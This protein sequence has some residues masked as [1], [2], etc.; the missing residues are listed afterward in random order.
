MTMGPWGVH[1][2]RTQTW[3]DFVP[4]WHDYLARCQ[5]MLRQGLFAADICY[6]QPEAAP[7]GFQEHNR[8]SHDYDNCSAEVVLTRM[9]VRDGRLVL[10]DG[11]SYHLLVLPDVPTMTPAL[12]RKISELVQAGATVIGPRPRKS[13]SLADYPVCDDEVKKLA[14]QVWADCDGNAVKERTF[15]RGRVV[16]GVPPEEFLRKAGVQP[17]FTSWARLD[18]IHRLAPDRDIYF[19]A[20]PRPQPVTAACI[21]RVSGRQP[22]LWWPDTGRI[23]PAAV[24]A[25]KDGGT[26]V[27]LPLPP[28]GSVFVVF[29]KSDRPLDPI[30]AVTCDGKTILS[31]TQTAPN[32]VVTKALYGVLSDPQRTRDVVRKV[33]QKVDA[34]EYSFQVARLAEGDD[35]AFNVVK[36]LV[37]EYR[38][39]DK[40]FT[41]TGND[42]D[43]VHLTGDSARIVVE[44]AVYG[45]LGDPQR[46][47]DVR[48]KLQHIL[49]TGESSFQVARLAQGDDPAVNVVK[50]L[51]LEYTL[52]GRRL[53][54]TGTDPQNIVLYEPPA[55]EHIVGIHCDRQG[56]PVLEA[57]RPGQYVLKTASGRTLQMDVPSLP[58]LEVTGPWEVRFPPKWGAP[59]RITL[60]KLAS[61]TDH[62][63]PGV[64]YFSG[65][66]TYTKTITVPNELLTVNRRLILDLGTVRV[67]ARLKLNGKDL[68]LLWSQPFR[69]DVTQTVRPG[70]NTL[71]VSVVNLWV[72]RLIGD[73]Q[74][75]EDSSRNPDG[76]LK[77]WPQ[78]LA[79]DSPSPTGR[80][81]F[82]TWRLWKKD[83]PLQPSG[84]IG[85]VTLQA[86][87][88]IA[89]TE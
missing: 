81:T 39:G 16:C 42:T 31:A 48:E 13:P 70:E 36:T 44:K 45:V 12:L 59:E 25:E 72:N 88:I 61:W 26:S 14:D 29:R 78:W 86:T 28:G 62:T 8:T 46:T 50:T 34:G 27:V 32:V 22:E 58:Q 47:R 85:P 53:S 80:F 17:D 55:D 63:D 37:V 75:P 40:S 77:E 82:T 65:T 4:A 10:P 15:G 24:F 43:T 33:Q 51:I 49:D 1:Y 35:P 76:T 67:M 57:R 21:F 52:E 54:A 84:L 73:E 87:Q 60:E 7:Q 74:L 18:Y 19:V 3:W 71:E 9:T 11:M 66:A 5:F 69:M 38:V 23:E 79:Q 20:N 2:E 6:L 68:G 64:K 83:A 30:A 41:V 56:R 89:G